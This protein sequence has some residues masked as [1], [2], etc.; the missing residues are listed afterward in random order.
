MV[1]ILVSKKIMKYVIK[2]YEFLKDSKV[3]YFVIPLFF[4]FMLGSDLVFGFIVF[5]SS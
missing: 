4:I 3:I 1:L 2:S 5:N